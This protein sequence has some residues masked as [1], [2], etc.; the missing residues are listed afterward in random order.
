MKTQPDGTDGTDGANEAARTAVAW[1]PVTDE[2]APEPGRIVWL[3][4]GAKVWIGAREHWDGV[5]VYT[6]T[7]GNIWH[8]GQCWDGD[9]EFD[10]DYQPTHWL[11]LPDLPSPNHPPPL[12]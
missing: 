10:D 1:Q 4:D 6:N 8:N 12:P 11:P 2:T 7:Y 5:L 9:C 3:W